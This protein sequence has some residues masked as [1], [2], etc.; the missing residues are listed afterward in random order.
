MCGI[1]GILH[2]GDAPPVDEQ[3]LASMRDVMSHRGPDAAGIWIGN[4]KTIGLAHR[5]LA[6][7]DLDP[8]SLQ[9]MTN[10]D[11]SIRVVFNGEI[12]N[13]RTLRSELLAAGHKFRTDHSDTEVLVHGYEEWGWEGL[14]SRLNGMFAI[15]LWDART[16][17]LWLARDR[18]GIKPLYLWRS[19]RQI[20]F[21]SEIKS[22]LQSPAVPRAV[23]TYAM[24][25]YLTGM[26][27]PAPRTLFHGIQKLP[28][29]CFLRIA[30]NGECIVQR[31]WQASDAQADLGKR[32]RDDAVS[33]VREL[34]ADAVSQQSIADV[35][36]GVFLSG[37]VDSGTLLASMARQAAGPIHTFSVGYDGFPAMDERR[38]AQDMA[39]RFGAEHKEIVV[40]LKSLESSWDDIVYHQDEPLADWVCLPLYH[41]AK[42]AAQDV[43]VVLV[44]EGADEQFCGYEGYLRYLRIYERLWKPYRRSIPSWARRLAA[45]AAERLVRYWP[46]RGAAADFVVRAGRDRDLFWG[47]AVTFW[48]TQ[49]HGLLKWEAL[50]AESTPG[51]GLI[52][53]TTTRIFDSYAVVRESNR[54]LRGRPHDELTR[55]INLELNY[56]LP[57]LLLMRVDKMTMA[58]SLEARVPFLDHR[59]VELSFGLPSDWKIANGVPKSILKDAVR[60]LL[61][62][63]VIDRP[64]IGFGAPVSEWLKG[65]F[66]R[67]VENEISNCGLFRS[68]W[69]HLGYIQ[70]MFRAHRIGARNY[71]HNLWALYNLACWYNRWI[72]P[73]RSI[74]S[75]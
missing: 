46:E 10:E 45:S 71:G 17:L 75:T 32:S 2:Q 25:H 61:P 8:S 50:S 64:K 14:L 36:V 26:A 34:V 41:V 57:E 27:A 56:R 67:R 49:K 42:L 72:E 47:G 20:I 54:Q 4:D 6:I 24:Y 68:G 48:E 13:H 3:L 9:P 38:A 62:D 37:G 44:G 1:C 55:M 52:D 60:G 43:K 11:G 51:S 74:G 70:W 39:R 35:P 65:E 31:Y 73:S 16:R 66:G 33:Q 7:V 12:Y 22:I 63:E 59:L 40:D 30:S 29:A 15:A 18:L 19:G 69:F 53:D 5:R 58:H 28:A 23:D 21:A